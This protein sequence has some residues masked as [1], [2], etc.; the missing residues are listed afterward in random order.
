MSAEG[1]A[2]KK[3]AKGKATAFDPKKPKR[4]TIFV[5]LSWPEWQDKYVEFV[6]DMFEKQKLSDD[7][8]LNG[9][10]AKMGKGPEVKKAMAFVQGLKKRL[11]L[12]CA[13]SRPGC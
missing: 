3:M 9:S 6:R 7:K 13:P 8:V 4:I 2:V 10:V 5:A 12:F 1:Q 11:A